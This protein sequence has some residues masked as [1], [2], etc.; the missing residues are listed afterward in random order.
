MEKSFAALD[1]KENIIAGLKKQGIEIPTRIQEMV[2]SPALQKCDLAAESETGSGKTLAYLLPVFQMVDPEKRENQAIVLV[3]TH[4]LAVQVQSQIKTLAENAGIPLKSA[5][6]IGDVNIKRQIEILKNDKPS[7]I[8]GS[9]GRILELIQMKKISAHSVKTIIID[10]A[11]RLLDKDNIDLVKSI[12]KTTLKERQLMFFS[13]VIPETVIQAARELTPD[14]HFLRAAK[15]KTVNENIRHLYIVCERREKIEILRKLMQILRP[16][17]AFAFINRPY[18]IDLALDKMKFHGLKAEAIYGSLDKEARQKAI[19]QIKTGSAS[20]LI[21]SDIAG[22][23]LDINDLD[24]VIS[25]DMPEDPDQYLHR[26]GRTGR[27]DKKGTSV[28]IITPAE[29]FLIGKFE[30][31]LGIKMEEKKV[32]RDKMLDVRRKNGK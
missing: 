22:R 29:K 26:A 4:E 12:V 30:K 10:E 24:L 15:Q 5:M 11:D 14:L 16:E 13:A 7:I 25:L 18:E 6:I 3:P 21:A 20:L 23:G 32:F 9:S 2:I 1:I 28:C 19:Q 31:A 17:R 8:V 27:V